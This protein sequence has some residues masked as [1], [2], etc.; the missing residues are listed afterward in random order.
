MPPKFSFVR[1]AES[2]ISGATQVSYVSKFQSP[3]SSLV[4]RPA[5]FSA[6]SRFVFA[7]YCSPDG[8]HCIDG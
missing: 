5:L 8:V 3:I 6:G 7:K 1:I 2:L 4:L